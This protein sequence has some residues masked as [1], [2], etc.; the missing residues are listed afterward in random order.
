M[1]TQKIESRS[2]ALSLFLLVPVVFASLLGL[3]IFVLLY[4]MWRG[5]DATGE[6]VEMI[7]VGECLE[8]AEAKIKERATGIGLGTQEWTKDGSH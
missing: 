2:T 7:F 1:S 4:L 8:E 3:S 5:E 6:R